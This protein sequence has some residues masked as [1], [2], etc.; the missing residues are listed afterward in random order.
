MKIAVMGPMGPDECA[1]YL[2][3]GLNAIG[4]DARPIDPLRIRM[5]LKKHGGVEMMND[6]NSYRKPL[7]LKWVA[8]HAYTAEDGVE[9]DIRGVP[10]LI[11]TDQIVQYDNDLPPIDELGNRPLVIFYHNEYDQPPSCLNPDIVLY[12]QPQLQALTVAMYP[13]ECSRWRRQSNLL[14]AVFPERFA[15]VPMPQK[16]IK[17]VTWVGDNFVGKYGTGA[18]TWGRWHSI[19]YDVWRTFNDKV[20]DARTQGIQMSDNEPEITHGRYVELVSSARGH[21]IIQPNHIWCSRRLFECIAM[22]TVPIIHLQVEPT[23]DEWDPSFKRHAQSTHARFIEDLGFVNGVNCYT[24]TDPKQLKFIDKLLR[25]DSNV[26][27]NQRIADAAY[28]LVLQRHTFQHR[29]KQV[30]SEVETWRN[31]VSSDEMLDRLGYS[32]PYLKREVQL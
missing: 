18:T 2:L 27:E 32:L 9:V 1:H 14:G 24:Y 5:M 11:I 25:D 20:N 17:G 28:E 30:L 6:H 12:G 29:A 23:G 31:I 22:G 26:E 4:C 8:D 10:I 3:D 21:V 16:T 19:A 15:R 13:Y 7:S